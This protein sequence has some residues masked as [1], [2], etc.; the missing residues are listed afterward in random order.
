MRWFCFLCCLFF[1]VT[2]SAQKLIKKTFIH[3]SIQSISID[4]TDC[5][6]LDLS[7]NNTDEI[8]IAGK[9]EGADNEQ[10]LVNLEEVG[11][12]L[13]I[14]TGFQ[15]SYKKRGSKF[16]ALTFVAIE[17]QISIPENLAVTLFGTSTLVNTKGDFK[18]I[19]ISLSDG[20][21]SLNGRFGSAR[22]KTQ[23]GD[24]QVQ[25]ASGEIQA[26]SNYGK[27]YLSTIPMGDSS[28]E[29]SSV[30]GDIYINQTN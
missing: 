25:S 6:S 26:K 2:G 4:L 21:C 12:N 8:V 10:V 18:E 22:V 20:D 11:T 1:I 29:L 17:L 28:Y 27:V 7:T 15:P 14:S 13:E 19:D 23:T 9:V 24:I 30:Q 16:G 3:S 5:Y